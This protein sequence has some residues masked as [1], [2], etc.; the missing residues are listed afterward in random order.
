MQNYI[1]VCSSKNDYYH[2]VYPHKDAARMDVMV[3]MAQVGHHLY[4]SKT[5][6]SLQEI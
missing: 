5:N 4:N 2:S 1:S 6:Q 3:E